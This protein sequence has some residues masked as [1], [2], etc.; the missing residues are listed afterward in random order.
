MYRT[1]PSPAKR[2]Q[3]ITM[4]RR[5]L[6]LIPLVAIVGALY[7]WQMGGQATPEQ[8]R[9]TLYGNVEIREA[10]LAFNGSEH[11][12]ELL[13][14]E[15][16]FVRAGQVLAR[17]RTELL[18]RARQQDQAEVEVRQAQLDKLLAGS[19]PEEIAAAQAQVKAAAARAR[20]SSD[21]WRRLQS[22]L[23]RKLSSAEEV[24]IA[25]ANADA[26]AAELD[27]AREN[28]KL[29]QIGPRSED[30]AAARAALAAARAGL[31]LTEQRLADAVLK[32]PFAGIVRDRLAEPGE[33]LTPQNPVL[34]LAHVSP[35][36][37]RSYVPET[38]LGRVRPG[39]SA[40]TG[41]AYPPGLRNA[42]VCLQSRW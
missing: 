32:A 9:L 2:N 6:L 34:T 24:E 3:V 16:D 28:L 12:A 17:Q 18:Q 36:W 1:G 11:L 30:I 22:L 26:A 23:E 19:R 8:F 27:A 41:I 33:Y 31:A 10:Q 21:S 39:M 13:V 25:Q 7:Y 14:E 38:E 40:N 35:V 37:V 42:R 15:G 5:F 29:L 4:S 20:A